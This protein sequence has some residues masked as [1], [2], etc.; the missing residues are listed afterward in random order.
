MMKSDQYD[1]ICKE[2]FKN[3]KDCSENHIF[4]ENKDIH[5]C[6]YYQLIFQNRCVHYELD[7]NLSKIPKLKEK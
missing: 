6:T 1:K 2:I 4:R 7:H 5:L 3:L